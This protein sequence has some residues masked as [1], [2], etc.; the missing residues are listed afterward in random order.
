MCCSLRQTFWSLHKGF[1]FWQQPRL[2][3]KGLENKT[4]F[5]IRTKIMIR[6]NQTSYKH[7]NNAVGHSNHVPDGDDTRSV[8]LHKLM[9]ETSREALLGWCCARSH[10]PIV[11]I[12]SS[13]RGE[14][15]M[16]KYIAWQLHNTLGDILHGTHTIQ[17][18][19]LFTC[20][21]QLL[22]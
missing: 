15:I 16:G 19:T 8:F 3:S 17:D 4:G 7:L 18:V 9:E 6:I 11:V 10:M 2:I 13:Q 12:L 20:Y 22:A 1:G 5:K 21:A 14:M